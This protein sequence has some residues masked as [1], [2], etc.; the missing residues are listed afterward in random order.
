[1][2]RSMCDEGRKALA[3]HVGADVAH[4][5][6]LAQ[7]VDQLAG[8]V[9]D[10]A[11]VGALQ[12]ELVLGAAD[13][14]VDGQVLHRLQI[15]RRCPATPRALLRKSSMIV[16]SD[17][18]R[19]P[20]GFRLISIRP[21]L[22]VVLAPSTP[23]K[24]GQAGDVGI[25]EQDARRPAAAGSHPGVGDRLAGLGDGLDE[26]GVLGR[27]QALGDDHVEQRRSGPGWRWRPAWSPL[28]V[29][30]PDQ[31]RGRSGR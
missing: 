14:G 19:W 17:V 23:M 21:V 15:E 22:S 7:L 2:S 4:R 26:A 12:R 3:L 9:V 30:H 1:M 5:L 24:R 11:L 8:P 6:V 18:V 29:Q 16:A 27:E 13:V 25:L 20:S 10:Q 28:V 31:G